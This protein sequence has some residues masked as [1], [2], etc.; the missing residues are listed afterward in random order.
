MPVDNLSVGE[1]SIP[2]TSVVKNLA[3]TL[4]AALS[5]DQH[6][7]A[8]FRSYSFEQRPFIPYS[9]SCPTNFVNARLL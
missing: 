9:Q 8:I 2:F 3:I 1:A 4:D 6:V 5:F 7:S